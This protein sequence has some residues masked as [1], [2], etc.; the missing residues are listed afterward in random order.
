MYENEYSEFIGMFYG[1]HASVVNAVSNDRKILSTSPEP[2]FILSLP[3]PINNTTPTIYDCLDL[4]TNE[5]QLN[6]N[7]KYLVDEKTNERV[8]AT[9]RIMFWSFPDVLIIDLKRFIVNGNRLQKYSGKI[10]FSA[11]EPLNLS[12]YIVGYNAHEYVYELIGVCNHMGG[13][14]GGHYT[15]FVKYNNTSEWYCLNDSSVSV[16]NVSN[17]PT[18]DAYCLFYRKISK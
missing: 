4:Y 10:E 13:L 7:N 5:E 8:D 2:F 16:V 15:A 11:T 3:I 1:I 12:K 18:N 9:K 14:M 6:G 17:V